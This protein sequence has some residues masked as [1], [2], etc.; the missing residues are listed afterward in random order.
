MPAPPA[1]TQNPPSVQDPPKKKKTPKE[2]KKESTEKAEYGVIFDKLQGDGKTSYDLMIFLDKDGSGN[3]FDRTTQ[4]P[5]LITY[6]SIKD[7][8]SSPLSDG[9]EE[10]IFFY[11]DI[12]GKVIAKIDTVQ[13]SNGKALKISVYSPPSKLLGSAED[14]TGA[15]GFAATYDEYLDRSQDED[16][17]KLDDEE[18][19]ENNP[20]ESDNTEE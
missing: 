19:E 12:N 5:V 20:G 14:L 3:L 6:S 9:T 4:S 16:F 10:R 11:K 17:G 15:E 8:G 7:M 13:D 2:K 18:L 1:P